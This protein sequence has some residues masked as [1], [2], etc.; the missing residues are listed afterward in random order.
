MPPVRE[1]DPWRP[2]IEAPLL[3]AYVAATGSEP[4][5]TNLASTAW[6]KPEEP[7]FCE[8]LDYIFLG[9]GTKATWKPRA[10]KSLAKRQ[11]VLAVCSSYPA[12]SEP[13]DHVCIWCDLDLA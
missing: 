6:A 3:S 9:D 8:T 10:V 12:P 13:S 4:E 7:P 2:T 1:T 11:D 5:F